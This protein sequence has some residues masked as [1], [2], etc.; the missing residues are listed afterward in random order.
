MR[1][2]DLILRLE[3]HRVCHGDTRV[4]IN[5]G[6]ECYD[7]VSTSFIFRDNE[8]VLRAIP[9]SWEKV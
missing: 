6:E 8:V 1:I 4:I 5:N 9:Y 2:S 3:Q 7:I